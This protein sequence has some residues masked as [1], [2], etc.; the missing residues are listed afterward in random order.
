M[1]GRF[2]GFNA[3][4]K[5]SLE[6]LSMRGCFSNYYILDSFIGS[7]VLSERDHEHEFGDPTFA[8]K[9]S[10]TQLQTHYYCGLKEFYTSRGNLASGFNLQHWLKSLPA[11]RYRANLVR[12]LTEG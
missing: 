4:K 11:Y 7:M 9:M 8:N 5:G 1:V 6:I 12:F 10:G 3:F 2:V